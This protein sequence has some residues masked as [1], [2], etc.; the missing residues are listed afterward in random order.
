M[1]TLVLSSMLMSGCFAESKYDYGGFET[2]R[3][4]PIDGSS[5]VWRFYHGEADWLLEAEMVDKNRSG[6]S[7]VATIEYSRTEPFSL[8]YTVNWS[9][10]ASK[11]IRIHG[12]QVDTAFAWVDSEADTG[13]GEVVPRPEVAAS[14]WTDFSPPIQF[15]K[16]QMAP[17]DNITTSTGGVTYTSTFEEVENCPN[18]W[19]DTWECLR[20]LLT[21]SDD[22]AAPFVGTWW[23]ATTWGPSWF[24]PTVMEEP[25][26]LETTSWTH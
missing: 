4:F 24:Q 11:G 3:Y 22:N 19:N 8:L 20:F 2:Y 17:G 25:W 5:R 9:S 13:D 10:D 18:L 26:V 1:R 7:Q 23:L 6:G 21:S 14:G 15:A 16:H 12:Y